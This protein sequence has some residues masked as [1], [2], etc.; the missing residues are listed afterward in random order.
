MLQLRDGAVTSYSCKKV[1][2]F[3]DGW[4]LAAVEHD[5]GTQTMYVPKDNV[6]KITQ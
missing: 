4:I 2:V 5:A 3:E 6:K 1:T